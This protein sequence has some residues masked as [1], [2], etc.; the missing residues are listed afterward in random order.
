MR[1]PILYAR[2]LW[3]SQRFGVVFLLVVGA[4]GAAYSFYSPAWGRSTFTLA[5]LT[6]SS[7]V[8]F[9]AYIPAALLY[10]GIYRYY[11]WRSQVEVTEQG[12]RV[13][14]LLR[15]VVIDYDLIRTVRVQPLERHFQDS[16][17]RLIRPAHRPLLSRPAL[18]LRL[19][20]DDPRLAQIRRSL[21]SQ[22]VAED[23]VALP[24]PDPD[25]MSWEISTRIPER[26][27][28]NLGGRRRRKRR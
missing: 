10:A 5:G 1:Q 13:R 8:V 14:N 18:F 4:A 27:A 6:L 7:S 28:G 15:G 16:R 21:G 11:Q 2:Q 17:R 19:R 26:G 9:L 23:T 25:A 22:L 12:V 20:A 24:I 3:R